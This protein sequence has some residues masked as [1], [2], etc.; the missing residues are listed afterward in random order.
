MDGTTT[1]ETAS[2]LYNAATTLLNLF[3]SKTVSSDDMHSIFTGPTGRL[4]IAS[5]AVSGENRATRFAKDL[6]EHLFPPLPEQARISGVIFSIYSTGTMTT[7][8]YAVINRS[9]LDNIP[10]G[11]PTI[12]NLSQQGE[13]NECFKGSL[14][15]SWEMREVHDL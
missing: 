9:L 8:E 4:S 12:V 14:I 1:I 15:I 3:D 5:V 10:D 11:V 6:L 7:E 2:Q 13:Y